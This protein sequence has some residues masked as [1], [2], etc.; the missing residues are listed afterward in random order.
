M[1]PIKNPPAAQ[2]LHLFFDFDDTL[3]DFDRFGAQYVTALAGI[4]SR[5]MGGGA[6]K[7]HEA[8]SPALAASIGRYLRRFLGNPLQGYNA[9]I[10]EERPRVV[11]DVFGRVGLEAPDAESA[12][13]LAVL[14]QEKALRR[15]SALFP[16]ADSALM[17]LFDR[18]YPIY[19]ASSQESKYLR[20]AMTGAPCYHQIQEFYGPDLLDCAKEGPEFYGRLF[21]TVGVDPRCA[22][23]IDD[24]VMCLEWAD[25]L[26]ARVIQACVRTM[27]EPVAT[28]LFFEAFEELVPLVETLSQAGKLVQDVGIRE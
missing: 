23:V 24:Q 25:E 17:E 6:G 13:H 15:C 16:G 21:Q 10:S 28:D 26:G 1:Q 27:P 8:I 2:K 18:R 19:L 3:S 11:A 14:L 7:W 5:E 12:G 20:G 22:V 4:L 9:W